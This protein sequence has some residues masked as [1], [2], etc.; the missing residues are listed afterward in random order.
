MRDEREEVLF[1]TY[2]LSQ[3]L[4][5]QERKLKTKIDNLVVDYI[6]KVSEEDFTKIED[7]TRRMMKKI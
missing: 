3:C 6:L 5:L 2:D 1:N 4:Q 7:M